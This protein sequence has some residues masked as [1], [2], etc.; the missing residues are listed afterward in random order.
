MLRV[1]GAI[2]RSSRGL[3]RK[4]SPQRRNQLS[5]GP[6]LSD[7]L[8]LSA[9]DSRSCLHSSSSVRPTSTFGTGTREQATYIIAPGFK[10]SGA[11]STRENP[12]PG[13]Y[14]NVPGSL[15]NQVESTLQS[16]A[17][18]SF[19]HTDRLLSTR[20]SAVPGPGA[21][22]SVSSLGCQVSST[23]VTAPVSA[24]GTSVRCSLEH[25]VG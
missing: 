22:K 17:V 25:L 5:Q 10:G 14:R 21:Y 9:F 24:F 12:G 13:T 7:S 6:A 1:S 19:N 4:S 3:R 8:S 15:G 18:T 11:R 20:D 23:R 2:R 16:S